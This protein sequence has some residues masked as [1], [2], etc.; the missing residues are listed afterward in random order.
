[1]SSKE[2]LEKKSGITVGELMEMLLISDKNLLIKVEYEGSYYDCDK[3][4]V[5]EDGVYF[6]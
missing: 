5:T 3:I 6:N 1:M 4:E 2:I